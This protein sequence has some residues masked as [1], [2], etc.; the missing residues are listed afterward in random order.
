MV[1][2]KYLIAALFLIFSGCCY[3]SE[4]VPDTIVFIRFIEQGLNNIKKNCG[5]FPNSEQGLNVLTSDQLTCWKG[6]YFPKKSLLDEWGR[7]IKYVYPGVHNIG[8]FDLYSAGRDG[9]YG[10]NDD[11]NNW[12]EEWAQYYGSIFL[13]YPML[14][15]LI[16]A[17]VIFVIIYVVLI[18][19]PKK[20]KGS[21]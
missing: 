9:K 10:T 13:K 15:S 16:I 3:S 20:I 7:E 8:A 19:R 14:R 5:F 21:S 17:I 11:I 6:P 1:F 4:P 18:G 12:N 2:K